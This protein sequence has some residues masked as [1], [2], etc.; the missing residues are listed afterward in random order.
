[1]EFKHINDVWE[2]L[3]QFKTVDE[4]EEAFG[5]IPSKF[6]SFD[7]TNKDT[8]KEDGWIEVC[9]SYWDGNIGEYEYDYHTIE[10]VGFPEKRTWFEVWILGY[11]NYEHVTDFESLVGEYDTKK[12]A[13][14]IAE[15]IHSLEDAFSKEDCDRIRES[16]TLDKVCV[17]V[18]EVQDDGINCTEAIDSTE[19]TVFSI[20]KESTKE[21]SEWIM[22]PHQ[23]RWLEK[24][25]E[26]HYIMAD[27]DRICA[28][29][30]PNAKA[31]EVHFAAAAEH[32]R[33]ADELSKL[34][35]EHKED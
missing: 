8:I 13:F 11:D 28:F 26:D 19:V 7:I 29:G 34:L 3:D 4:L 12:E 32:I 10:V 15:K 23:K 17:V 21:M 27:H 33:F 1:M 18:E 6:G 24:I 2:Y 30:A 20:K 31:A 16:L 25:I 14:A 5:E 35:E 9:N 22:T